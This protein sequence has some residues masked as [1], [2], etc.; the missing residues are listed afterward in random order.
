LA[1]PTNIVVGLDIG[2]TKIC[3]IVGEITPSGIDIIGIGMSPSKGLRR[4]VVI[5]IDQTVNSIRRAVEE[6]EL[7]SGI[8]IKSVFAG[9]AGSHIRGFNSR[10]VVAVSGKNRE[11]TQ[12]DIDR[13]IDAAKAVAIS[14]DREIIHVLPQ[15]FIVDDQRGI[16]EPLGMSGIRLEVEVH[17]VTGAVTSAQNIIKS[18]NK[19]GLEVQDIVLE[20]L[21]SA[22]AVLNQDERELGVLLLDIG[23]GTTDVAVFLGGGVWHTSVLPLGGDHV[24]NDIA[25]GLRTPIAEAE[26]IKK[27]YGCALADLVDPDEVIVVPSVGGEKERKIPRH[28]LCEIIEPRIEEIFS[29]VEKEIKSL[30]Y[31]NLLAAG[32][33]I[34]GGTAIMDGVVE[35]AERVFELPVRRGF[36]KGV[37]GLSD[38]VD[39]P[40]FSTGVGLVLYGRKN[41]DQHRFSKFPKDKL[42]SRIIDRMKKWL[43]EF[44]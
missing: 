1:K 8:K 21:A 19:A 44:F 10:G 39:N 12:Y 9:I 26:R 41:I 22:E 29:L 43:T 36:P 13:A 42:F 35:V 3:A 15:E 40:I 37:G 25:V 2:T 28:L 32:V 6:A 33:V 31:G 7:M 30:G 4:G 16:K 14:A 11:I 5:N 20:Q 34:T 27:E 38:V 18:V 17:I 24:T 23:G